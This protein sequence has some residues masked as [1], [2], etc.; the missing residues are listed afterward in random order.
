MRTQVKLLSACVAMAVSGGVN[1]G[2]MGAANE[3]FV[4][5]ATAPQNFFREDLM[6]RVCDP[7]QPIQVFVDEITQMPSA[8]P[9]GDIL[10]QGDHFVVRC[11]ALGSFP[12]PLGGADIAVY[13]Y[14]GGSAT[15]VAPVSDP[16]GASAG[17]KTYLDASVGACDAQTGGVGGANAWPI[18]T[19][20]NN[21]ELYE[22]DTA[23]LEKTQ[24]PD[25]GISDVEPSIFTG[26][27]ALDAGEE[28]LGVADKPTQ[29]Y[30]DLGNL[31][32]LPGPGL[33]F[34]TAVTLAM[35]DELLDDQNGAGMLPDCPASPSRA[36]R[37]S[38]D[39][40]PS[41]PSSA[42]RSVFAGQVNDWSDVAPY[43]FAMD[44]S[45]TNQ[46]DNVH[47]CKRTN[48]SGTHAQFS[49]NF[50]GTNCR[51]TSNIAMSEV[52]DGLSASFAGFAGVYANS[53][54]SDMDKC[55][56]ALGSGL[57]FDGDFDDPNDSS[58]SNLP[59]TAYPGAGDSSV[60]P[61]SGMTGI[62]LN[63]VVQVRVGGVVQNHPLG[64]TYDN[65]GT[66]FTAFGMGYQSLEKNT[67]LGRP[68]RFVKVDGVAPTLDN[69]VSGDYRDVFYLSYQNRLDGSGD[70]DLQTG[71]IRT[72]T[73]TTNQ[74]AV[75]EEFFKIWNATAAGAL[76]QVNETL[77]VD[78]DGV[79]GNGDEW[80]GGY[81]TPVA[82]ASLAYNGTDPETP[83][84]R[85]NV[86]GSPDSCQDLGFVR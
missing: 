20:G 59:P 54:S 46:G 11:Q 78:P 70:P 31:N 64:L 56:T 35:Y 72:A 36:E 84:A 10:N 27:L 75:A 5:G 48:G 51:A 83:W 80:Q 66:P 16:A 34:G 44:T 4:G 8:T 40:M 60:V 38:I 58:I 68:Y 22:C 3:I 63:T 29:P 45:G 85:Q 69:A 61:G 57:G 33:V 32:V 71:A 47:I 24:N 79:P 77:E 2:A 81:V 43:G 15:G 19:T 1:A 76:A 49:V 12:S 21:Y 37:D 73:A 41:M 67:S 55:L 25:A 53:G 26:A 74:K 6:Q 7:A 65:G 30:V 82:G 13:K 14:N 28:P 23:A 62:G 52:N 42:I 86:G 17:D 39:C 18:S 50:L 9:G